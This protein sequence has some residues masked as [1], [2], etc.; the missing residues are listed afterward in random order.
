MFGD[1]FGLVCL[2]WVVDRNCDEGC[3][4]GEVFLKFC[5]VKNIF[6]HSFVWFVLIICVYFDDYR[7][8]GFGGV[9]DCIG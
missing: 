4:F 9:F 2:F 1:L 8:V 5:V 6:V 3:V 7:F